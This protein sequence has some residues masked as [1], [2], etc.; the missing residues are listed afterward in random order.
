MDVG[1]ILL[2]LF[3]ICEACVQTSRVAAKLCR[4]CEELSKVCVKLS[5]R[6]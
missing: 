6:M 1:V 5:G 2:N 4:V 3:V